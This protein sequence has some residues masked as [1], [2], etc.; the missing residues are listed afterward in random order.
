MSSLFLERQTTSNSNGAS[1]KNPPA[2]LR[3]IF[4]HCGVYRI[5]LLPK[6]FC[7]LYLDLLGL[8]GR[9]NEQFFRFCQ[10]RTETVHVGRILKAVRYCGHLEPSFSRRANRFFRRQDGHLVFIYRSIKFYVF[11]HLSFARS[12]AY[13]YR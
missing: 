1:V 13:P 10:A 3:F 8:S 4:S 9:F 2:V 7:A 12:S 5:R 6:D 11:K